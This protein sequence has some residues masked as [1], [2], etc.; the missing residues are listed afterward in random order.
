MEQKF[1]KPSI[2]SIGIGQVKFR[3]IK[4]TKRMGKTL[5]ITGIVVLVVALVVGLVG[6]GLIVSPALA[7]KASVDKIKADGQNLTKAFQDRD[8]VFFAQV[9]DQTESDINGLRSER[10]AK[11]GWA[12]GLP[13]VKDFYTDSDYFLNA[14]LY[15]IDAGR[16]FI[17]I[18]TPFADAAGLKVEAN[19][20]IVEKSFAE[21]FSDWVALMPK[22]ANDIDPFLIKLEKV[23]DELA[24]VDASK[25]PETMGDVS[26]R[27]S[28][29]YAQTTLSSLN[30]YAPDLKQALVIVPKVL[31]V[32]NVDKRYMIIMQNNAEMRPT[33]G[34]WTNYATFKIRNA[35]PN[36]D[37]SSKDMY[38]ID[39]TLDALDAYYDF[40]VG[41]PDPLRKH[42][43]VERWFA[44][45]ANFSPDFPTSVAQFMK[46]YN[47]AM[48]VNPTEVKPV[49]GVFAID[50]DVVSELLEVT[51]PA[52]VNGVTYTQD[53]VT[54]ELEKIASLALKEQAN[55][56]K[57]LGDLMERMLVNV[58]ESDK[59]LWPKLIDK[60]V[61]LLNRKHIIVYMTDP[62][63]QALLE[64]YNYAGRLI[65]VPQG[66]YIAV[67]T[68][69]LGGDKTN[70]FIK[71]EITNTVENANGTLTKTVK[72]KYTYGPAE[73]E[74]AYFAKMYKDYVRLYVPKGSTLISVE[75]SEDGQGTGEE[76]TK[77][78]F[79]GFI[80]LGPGETQEITF[81]YTLPAASVKD[82][83][84]NLYIQKQAGM[85][86][87]S[88]IVVVNGKQNV[89]DLDT[90]YRFQVNKFSSRI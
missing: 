74:Y 80:T 12:K 14:G 87:E 44:R 54:L 78:Y 71:R 48:R 10:D 21:A 36:S 9:L 27:S 40:S 1:W 56:K 77:T 3:D 37:F 28:I 88:Y 86:A 89:L 76:L 68:A 65:D 50:T 42:L 43:L 19:Q 22:V 84:Y 85:N 62:E 15:A 70:M 52:T 29:V 11:F 55:R 4:V 81:K 64:K 7:L 67:I 60:G 59:N 45:D 5:G 25:Y 49:E 20:E 24:K 57:V 18:I 46:S 30:D 75:G 69:N 8:L 34:F 83:Q 16:E 79:S 32:G 63:I 72:V 23:G 66:D 13:K 90:D 73:G 26:V 38:S 82:G 39:Y 35:M 17:T 31:G 6:Y 33:G 58:F 2:P 61:D 47:L 53:N 51:G 41:L